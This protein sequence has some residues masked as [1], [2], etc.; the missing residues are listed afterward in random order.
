VYRVA[1]V[2]VVEGA[3]RPVTE[4]RSFEGLFCGL[5]DAGDRI[6]ATG[7]LETREDGAARL[8]V[9]TAAVAGGG[10]VQVLRV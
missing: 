8:V 10:V 5:A 9:G 6:R 1:D 4:V 3:A 2:R 7:R